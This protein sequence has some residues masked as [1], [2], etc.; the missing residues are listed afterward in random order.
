MLGQ[1]LG[2]ALTAQEVE[3]D[4]DRTSQ[5]DAPTFCLNSNSPAD[6]GFNDREVRSLTDGARTQ[7]SHCRLGTG[8][9]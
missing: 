4:L 3:I 7:L 9:A 1:L 8:A 5:P 2:A 6:F